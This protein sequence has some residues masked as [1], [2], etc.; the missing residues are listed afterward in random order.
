MIETLTPE[1]E[2][3]IPIYR[4]KWWKLAL[5]TEPIDRAKAAETVKAIYAAIGE[6]E[7]K[8]IFCDSPY[9][10]LGTIEPQIMF[11]QRGILMWESDFWEKIWEESFSHL[12][13]QLEDEEWYRLQSQ[14]RWW[15]WDL[16]ET[17]LKTQM[18]IEFQERFYHKNIIAGWLHHSSLFDFCITVLNLNYNPQ[19]WSLLQLVG[20]RC[21]WIFPYKKLAIVCDRPRI[22]SFD[23]QHRLHAEGGPAI[24]F[25]DGYSIYSYHG[26][27]LPEKYGKLHPREWQPQWL[28]EEENAELRRVLIQGIGYDR[29]A[30]ELA[31]VELDTWQEYTLLKIDTNFDVEPIYLLKMTCPSTG[32]IHALRVPP[33]I[34]SAREAIRWT[35]WGVDPEEFSVQT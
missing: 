9:A 6:K 34:N 23:S 7:P 15:E 5:S 24:Q 12:K 30:R 11:S 20:D 35:N 25:A 19:S 10:A 31:A 33:D 17:Q 16:K 2:A 32:F 28:L 18:D 26:V 21:G 8:I 4:E 1:Q 14:M 22:L 29:I 27:T 13:N 3:L